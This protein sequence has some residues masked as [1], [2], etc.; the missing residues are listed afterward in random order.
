LKL[1]ERAIGARIVPVRLPTIADIAARRRELFKESVVASLEEG[2][3]EEFL[4]TVGELAEQYEASEVAAAALK[5]LWGQQKQQVDTQALDGSD[6]A[7]AEPGMARLFIN[8][9]RQ[10][11]LRPSDVVGAIAN[12][13]GISGNVIGTIDILDDCAFVEV[14]LGAAERVVRALKHTTLRGRKVRVEKAP[15]GLEDFRPDDGPKPHSPKPHS[16]KPY[17]G[18]GK[19]AKQHAGSKFKAGKPHSR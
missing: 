16:P 15:V 11:G 13:A 18:K 2:N 6:G 19:P 7:R 5:L 1:I 10:Q 17:P 12:E 8:V 3:F 9:G 14:P 4:V